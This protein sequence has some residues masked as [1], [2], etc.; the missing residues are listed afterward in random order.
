MFYTCMLWSL[1][2]W[3]GVKSWTPWVIW[4]LGFKL[5]MVH[6]RLTSA[7]W[8]V[9]LAL[10]MFHVGFTSSLDITFFKTLADCSAE[11]DVTSDKVNFRPGIRR[12]KEIRTSRVCAHL[13]TIWSY[14]T[15]INVKLRGAYV[16]QHPK[17]P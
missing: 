13:K 10:K 8:S 9:C 15:S 7:P 11:N 1:L 6:L 17:E 2:N 3:A 14:C 12:W 16:H 4:H 5:F